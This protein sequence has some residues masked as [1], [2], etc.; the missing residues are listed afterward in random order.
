MTL[1]SRH[2]HDMVTPLI[3]IIL[4]RCIRPNPQLIPYDFDDE[5][6]T[7]QLRYS[8]VVETV[9]MRQQGFPVRVAFSPFINRS[10]EQI[11]LSLIRLDDHETTGSRRGLVLI[12]KGNFFINFLLITHI[13][14]H[15]NWKKN[16]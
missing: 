10:V 1:G 5:L 6:V 8:S 16:P 9:L 15:T 12:N 11:H 2:G 14:M 7:A 4:F 13:K 3:S